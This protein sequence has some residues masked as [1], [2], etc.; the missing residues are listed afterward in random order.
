MT[1][2]SQNSRYRLQLSLASMPCAANSTQGAKTARR[3]NKLNKRFV[4]SFSRMHKRKKERN[5]IS[6]S[7][8]RPFNKGASELQSRI[9]AVRCP[10]AP[11]VCNSIKIYLQNIYFLSIPV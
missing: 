6:S 7:R 3:F 10:A 2:S 11:D 9:F 5:N 8:A 1:H 4:K